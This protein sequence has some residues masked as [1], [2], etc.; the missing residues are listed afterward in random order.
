[1]TDKKMIPKELLARIKQDKASLLEGCQTEVEA[2][3]QKYN[4][5]LVSVPRFDAEGKTIAEVN[6]KILP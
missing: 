6:I 2:V 3:L 4:C 5:Q 1:M